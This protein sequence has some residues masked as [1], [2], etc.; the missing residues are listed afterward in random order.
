MNLRLRP[1]L[2]VAALALGLLAAPARADVGE[3]PSPLYLA[4]PASTLA[5]MG[6][7]YQLVGSL[8]PA[9]TATPTGSGTGPAAGTYKYVYTVGGLG[10]ETASAP[11]GNVVADGSEVQIGSLP[12][13]GTV[14]IYRISV[15]APTTSY[16]FVKE[17]TDGSTV[18][19]D[20]VPT[21]SGILSKSENRVRS[22]LF[23][24]ATPCV[25]YADFSP[26]V[27]SPGVDSTVVASVP[28]SP[29]N[30]GWVVDGAGSVH[31]PAGAWTF[32]AQMRSVATNGQAFLT[33]AVWKV[34]G[35]GNPVGGAVLASADSAE[36]IITSTNTLQ[37]AVITASLP[38]FSLAE[39][40]HLYIQ[41]WR[42]QTVAYTTFA[43]LDRV[44]TMYLWDG[45]ASVEHPGAV[46]DP[47]LPAQ[48]APADGSS[49][50]TWPELAAR[51]D[52]PVAGD[53]GTLDFQ[54]CADAAC[55]TVLESGSSAAGIANGATGTWSP[56]AQAYGTY[57][58]RVR[59]Q[60]AGGGISSWSSA[61]SFVYA[62]APPPEEPAPPPVGP[63]WAPVAFDGSIGSDGLTLTWR[64]PLGGARV[65][66]YA[67]YVDGVLATTV[68]GTT[69]EAKLG[70]LDPGDGRTFALA[71]VDSAGNSSRL[72]PAL[73]GVPSL[74]GLDRKA[75]AALAAARG[76]FLADEEMLRALNG[77]AASEV[78]VGQG[79]EAWALVE[80]GSE[81]T[82]TVVT[83]PVLES[84]VQVARESVSCATKRHLSVGVVLR[85]RARLD[86]A[87]VAGGR[88]LAAAHVTLQPGARTVRLRTPALH[89][90]LRYLLRVTVTAGATKETSTLA[91]RSRAGSGAGASV[92]A[93][94]TAA[95]QGTRAALAQ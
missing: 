70:P 33:V 83:L 72:T 21:T 4:G 31:F 5:T 37:T 36:T 67:L 81:L 94:E 73:V 35:S 87:L 27:H 13:S 68:D 77:S 12:S 7:S 16:Q 69:L 8:Y 92:C 78:V 30:R 95:G 42:H 9:P 80:V 45:V 14:R 2:V 62:A 26:G 41:F 1:L 71:A 55:A 58:W 34:D 48:T 32:T 90:D 44:A 25:G 65:A 52:D 18:V 43:T 6:G 28:A 11:S 89:T 20:D 49:T 82:V 57:Y 46:P 74:V 54:L 22:G 86:V 15:L 85:E 63:P 19:V 53:T 50:S 64:P 10:A 60:D 93:I 51:F 40:E 47:S 39:D 59:A 79:P 91:L 17:V 24:C 3:Y 88:R 23:G 29:N 61:R 75:A 66:Y 76:L 38:A 56:A 84:L